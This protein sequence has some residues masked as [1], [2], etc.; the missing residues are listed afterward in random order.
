MAFLI[1]FGSLW[2]IL[3]SFEHY[4]TILQTADSLEDFFF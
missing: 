3:L 1:N 4:G 2:A